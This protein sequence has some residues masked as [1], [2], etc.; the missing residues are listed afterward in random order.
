MYDAICASVSSLHR[1]CTNS[2]ITYRTSIQTKS[3]QLRH[4]C[5]YTYNTYII[6]TLPVQIENVECSIL[7]I[8]LC[9]H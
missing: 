9:N 2:L 4:L 5:V 8:I 3:V 7:N 1:E 6:Y